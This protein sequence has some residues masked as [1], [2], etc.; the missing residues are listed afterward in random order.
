MTDM[1]ATS[2]AAQ[3]DPTTTHPAQRPSTPAT[4]LDELERRLFGG[5][6]RLGASRL[7]T[8]DGPAGSG[9]TTL[10]RDLAERVR[11]RGESAEIFH[12]DEALEGW[13]G[14]DVGVGQLLTTV[15]VPW[16]EG[17]PGSYRRYDWVGKGWAEEVAVPVADV[18]V[19]EGCGCAPRAAAAWTNLLVWVQ[20]DATTRLRRGLERDGEEMREDWLRWMELEESVFE[21]EG[22]R[23]RADVYL[24]GTGRIATSPLGPSDP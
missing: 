3:P 13:T 7:V 24:D 6:P 22:V 18:L 8:I 12:L 16:S 21:R 9:K 23:S 14:I 19:V 1:R 17:R 2:P 10:A 11:A 15:L 20:T 4:T 5:P